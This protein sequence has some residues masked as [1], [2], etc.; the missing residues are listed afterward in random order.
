MGVSRYVVLPGRNRAQTP[1][2]SFSKSTVNIIYDFHFFLD[3]ST[4]LGTDQHEE[5]DMMSEEDP[6]N[7][8]ESGEVSRESSR[9][10]SSV[11]VLT[12]DFNPTPTL[13]KEAGAIKKQ[14]SKSSRNRK[15]KINED[16]I[17]IIRES[18]AARNEIFKKIGLNKPDSLDLFFQ[19]IA[20]SVKLLRPE[21]INEAKLR[22]MQLVFELEQRNACEPQPY[23]EP[24]H[25]PQPDSAPRREPQQYSDSYPASSLQQNAFELLPGPSTP[26]ASSS[27][28]ILTTYNSPSSDDYLLRVDNFQSNNPNF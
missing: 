24:R 13:N 23:S 5:K 3:R 11:S 2:S 28:N 4:S 19:S 27:G 17:A 1:V 9:P 26:S 12:A 7:N 25:E 18:S 8:I 14:F 15:E 20:A 10:G 6:E 22:T 16:I 21:L